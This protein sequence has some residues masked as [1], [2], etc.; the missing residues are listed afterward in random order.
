MTASKKVLLQQ[1]LADLPLRAAAEEHAV[2]HHDAEPAPRRFKHRPP[3]A[4]TNARSPLRLR[5]HAEPE[6]RMAVILGHLAAPLVE[7]ER[8]VGDHPVVQ[9]QLALVDQLRVAD[10]VSLLDAGVVAARGAAC[11]SCRW[12][13]CRGSS[14]GR[15]ASGCAG[16]PSLPLDVV[17]ALDQHAAGPGGRI[18]DAHA[19]RSA[20]AARR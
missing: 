12:P 2:R 15:G 3:C 8:R 17:G 5:R 11:S 10:R 4:G 19:V 9:Q 13:T 1:S 7:A 14:P 20:P 16:L 18:A 6:A